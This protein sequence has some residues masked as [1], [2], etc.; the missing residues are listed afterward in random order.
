MEITDKKIKLKIGRYIK[1]IG[2]DDLLCDNG[3]CITV[4]TQKGS[5]GVWDFKSLNMS[6]K[7]FKDLK[8]C[9]LVA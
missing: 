3:A 2:K 9:G 4:P 7:L 6:K 8:T 1:N 5:W